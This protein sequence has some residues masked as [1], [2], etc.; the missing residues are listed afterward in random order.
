[1]AVE[2]DRDEIRVSTDQLNVYVHVD[3]N[4]VVPCNKLG[5][6][7]GSFLL[8]FDSLN[9]VAVEEFGIL[10]ILRRSEGHVVPDF[11]LHP[12][13]RRREGDQL[14]LIVEIDFTYQTTRLGRPSSTAHS[15]ID[16]IV[17]NNCNPVRKVNQAGRNVY[18]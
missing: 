1:V 2:N 13:D 4:V 15:A 9:N 8:V 5:Q 18:R 11:F 16:P 6:L 12:L 14:T 7:F 3:Q 10:T 17:G